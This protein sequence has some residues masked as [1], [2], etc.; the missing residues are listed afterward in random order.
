MLFDCHLHSTISPDGQSPILDVCR[1]AVRK[2]A[3]V[4]CF[5]EHFD[6]NPADSGNRYYN[7]E[8]F[9]SEI[10]QAKSLF[11]GK[12][13]ILFGIEFSEPHQY[14]IEFGEMR[15]KGF[16]FILGSVH[17][18]ADTW[19]GAED[20]L[21]KYSPEEV[22]N[23]H[24]EETLRMVEFGG[25]DA[26]AHMDF[27]RRFLEAQQEPDDLIRGI[28]STIIR[29]NIALELNSSPLRK[30]K[31]FSLPSPAILQKYEDLGGKHVTMGSDAHHADEICSGFEHLAAQAAAH[32]LVPVIY[33]GRKPYP[34]KKSETYFS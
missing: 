24:Y 2:G 16:D 10:N 15:N 32:H 27:P 25:F 23:L 17:A 20:L 18:I 8:K 1:S 22:F 28:L 14:P 13:E 34:I 3:S 5:T 9:I 29:S 19:A 26:L 11:S 4:I 6:L 21:L 33:R 12:I 30:G 31:E 7:H